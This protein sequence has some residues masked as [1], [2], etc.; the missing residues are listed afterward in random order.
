M[1]VVM[2]IP[3]KTLDGA[4]VRYERWRGGLNACYPAHLQKMMGPEQKRGLGEETHLHPR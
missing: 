3:T 1:E 4:E 2:Q